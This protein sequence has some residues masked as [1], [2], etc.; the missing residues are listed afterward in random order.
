MHAIHPSRALNKLR[1]THIN[2]LFKSHTQLFSKMTSP[3]PLVRFYDLS[4]PK[5]WSPTCWATRYALNYK[6]IPYVT[7]KL[8]YPDIKPTCEKLFPDMTGLVATVPIIEALG[9]DYKPLNDSTPI[10]M[11]LNERFTEEMGYKHLKDVEK[12]AGYTSP[13]NMAIPH[14]ILNDV[15]ENSLDPHDGSKE[16]FKSTREARWKCELKDFMQVRGGGEEAVWEEL[17]VEWAK[18]RERMNHDDGQGER[19]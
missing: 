14:W 13:P 8:S 17:K 12:L 19:K 1:T 18:L 4:G 7:V 10:A 9:P 11:L 2:H 3:E 15:Y 5:T 6:G 16:Y